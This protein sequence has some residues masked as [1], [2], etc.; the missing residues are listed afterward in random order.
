MPK[1][2]HSLLR[3]S[4]PITL[5]LSFIHLQIMYFIVSIY[6]QLYCSSNI[7]IYEAI[8]SWAIIWLYVLIELWYWT[9]SLFSAS[10]LHNTHFESKRSFLWP[11]SPWV[12]K[13]FV[14]L[15]CG[16][17]AP[18][19]RLLLPHIKATSDI[20]IMSVKMTFLKYVTHYLPFIEFC[21]GRGKH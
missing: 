5:S 2:I 8:L 19:T 13:P 10:V 9:L 1:P 7:Y 20:W 14:W 4:L 16:G 12:V 11:V 15:H 6:I 18:L 21:S 3:D 17:L